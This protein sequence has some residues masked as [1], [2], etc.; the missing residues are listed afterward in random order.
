MA[1]TCDLITFDL[2]YNMTMYKMDFEPFGRHTPTGPATW[3]YIKIP[4]VFLQSSK[5]TIKKCGYSQKIYIVGLI[6]SASV[7][8]F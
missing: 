4:N 3:G 8:H 7:T 1:S 2:I 5:I 6:R